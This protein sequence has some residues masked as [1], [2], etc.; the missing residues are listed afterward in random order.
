[1]PT[2]KFNSVS[3]FIEELR[4]S[5]PKDQVLRLTRRY[6]PSS[7][8]PSVRYVQIVATYLTSADIVVSLEKF[9]GEDWSC[10]NEADNATKERADK[11]VEELTQAARQVGADV[12]P[13]CLVP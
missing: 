11:I 1:M 2:L 4:R 13:G 12:R 7:F 5:V 8:S 3:E 10:G 6:N 9:V